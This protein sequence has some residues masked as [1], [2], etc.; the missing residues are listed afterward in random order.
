MWELGDNPLSDMNESAAVAQGDDAPDMME[1]ARDKMREFFRLPRLGRRGAMLLGGLFAALWAISGIYM[2]HP[3]EQGMVL[4]FGKWV[5]TAEPGL[6]YHLP[7]PIETV[8][9]PRVTQINQLQIG[10]NDPMATRQSIQMLTGDENILE[11]NYVVFWKIKDPAQF[12][13]KLYDPEDMVRMAAESTMREAV[14][15]F[16]IQ[17]VL[18]DKRQQVADQARDGLQTLL[19]SYR[20]GIQIRE[21]QL[22]RVDPPAAVIDAFNDVQRAR[23][24]QER[25]RNDA[26]AYRNDILPRARGEAQ[27]IAQDAEAYKTQAIDLATGET[28]SF[29]A[30]EDVYHQA[31]EVVSSRLYYE[32]MDD[33][34]RHAKSVLVDVSGKGVGAVQPYAPL[35]LLKPPAAP[36]AAA[37]G[38]AK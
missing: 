13:F 1:L 24:D 27:R 37:A 8:A 38:G 9:L 33:L 3:D 6:H 29:R 26:D 28:N 14:S 10:L 21:V 11:A 16:P 19:D 23:A 20:T 36:I 32:G 25:A 5:E 7:Y 12:L 18:S 17:A 15:R 22:L 4:R 2:V 30:I 35:D 31:P 34:L